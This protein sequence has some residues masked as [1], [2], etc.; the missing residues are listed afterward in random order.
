MQI[1]RKD[2]RIIVSTDL[3]EGHRELS[4]RTDEAGRLIAGESFLREGMIIR[5]FGDV[6]ELRNASPGIAWD[7]RVLDTASVDTFLS[8]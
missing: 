6:V 8:A 3:P 5:R 4:L 1:N 2:T 7:R